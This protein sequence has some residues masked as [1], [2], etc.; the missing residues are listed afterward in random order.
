MP[1]PRCAAGEVQLVAA[2]HASGAAARQLADFFKTAGPVPAYDDPRRLMQETS[3]QVL[4]LDR[5]SNVGLD[6]LIHCA[7]KDVGIF[8]L[9]PAVESLA[10]AQALSE[11]LEPSTPLLHIWPHFADGAGGPPHGTGR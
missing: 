8:S 7:T 10:E 3:P 6:F 1:W 2:G 11:A 4:L 5:P 9:G